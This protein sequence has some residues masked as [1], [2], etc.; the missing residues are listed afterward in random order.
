VSWV[1]GVDGC[2]GGWV[3]ALEDLDSGAVASAWGATFADV[4]AAPQRPR[5]IGVDVPIG[6]LPRAE[7]GGRACD[8]EARALLGRR[9]SSVFSPATRPALDALAA[10]L[11]YRGVSDANRATSPAGIGLSK[12]SFAIMP[13]ITDVDRSMTPELQARVFE[14]HPEVAFIR[15]NG[16]H[17][18]PSKKRADGREGRERALQQLGYPPLAEWFPEPWPPKA[19]ADDL[20]D[21]CIV[22]WTAKRIAIG[23]AQR[24]PP[25]PPIDA[26]GLRMEIW[27]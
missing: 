25:H 2:P 27:S 14:V 5:V 12:Q 20:L 15:A 8:R 6:L 11:P 17:L 22:C 3:V 19:R 23:D 9:G 24:V 7:R 10:G 1:A 4:L 18:L 13:K 21:A 16:Q 26:R